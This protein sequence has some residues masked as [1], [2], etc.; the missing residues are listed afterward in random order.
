MTTATSTIAIVFFSFCQTAATFKRAHH[1]RFR[2]PP[3]EPLPHPLVLTLPFCRKLSFTAG[4]VAV[5][6]L[7]SGKMFAAQSTWNS[8]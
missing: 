6:A 7:S 4:A 1:T 2:K 5:Q 3:C 8:C